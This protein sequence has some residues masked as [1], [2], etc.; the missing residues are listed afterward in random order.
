MVRYLLQDF[1]EFDDLWMWAESAK[2]LNF[3]KIINLFNVVEMVFHTLN[4]DIFAGLNAL[5]LQHL[6]ESS[7]SLLRN[8]SILYNKDMKCQSISRYKKG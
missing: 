7:F 6:R 4:G 5:G 1:V 8:Q 3:S 2:S